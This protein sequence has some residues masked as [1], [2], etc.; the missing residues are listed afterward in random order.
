M[1]NSLGGFQQFMG[2]PIQFMASKKINIPQEYM[3][4]PDDAIQYLMNTGK[5]T[6]QDYN[7]ANQ[8]AKQ[9]Q[10]NPMFKQF[11]K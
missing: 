3:N 9:I 6:Q 5:I 7:K 8:L 10:N 2:N 1:Q 11:F 4:N